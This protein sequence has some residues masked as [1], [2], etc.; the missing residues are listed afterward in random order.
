MLYFQDKFTGRNKHALTK[1]TLR[2]YDQNSYLNFLL[3]NKRLFCNICKVSHLLQAVKT[4]RTSFAC[5]GKHTVR[6]MTPTGTVRVKAALVPTAQPLRS[7][8]SFR[9]GNGEQIEK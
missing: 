1:T 9:T 4:E 3:E 7:L 6:V 5:D 2:K 8:V